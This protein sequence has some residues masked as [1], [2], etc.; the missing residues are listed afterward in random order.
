M[1][2]GQT[3]VAEMIQALRRFLGENAMMAYLVM[4]ARRLLELRRVLKPTGSLYLHCDP[5]ASHYLKIVLDNVFGK[6]R[7][8]SEISWKRSSAHNDAKQR[9][10]LPGNV[11][12]VIL[13][14][15]KSET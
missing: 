10:K 5:V 4:M 15:T 6:T 3:Q 13:F 11:W 1:R 8:G 7:F 2:D 12:D 9:R 14:Y